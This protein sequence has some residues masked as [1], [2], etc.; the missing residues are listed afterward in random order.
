ML[1]K[2]LAG[3]P[4]A[5]AINLITL[6]KMHATVDL[7]PAV[8]IGAVLSCPASPLLWLTPGRPPSLRRPVHAGAAVGLRSWQHPAC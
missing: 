5:S 1:I 3:V 4:L 7:G 2:L 6:K 8:L